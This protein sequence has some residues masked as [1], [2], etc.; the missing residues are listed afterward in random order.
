MEKLRVGVIGYGLRGHLAKHWHQPEEGGRSVITAF[1]ELD[2]ALI[3][4]FKAEITADCFITKDYHELLAREDVDAVAIL[5]EDWKHH[6][7]ALDAFK[8]GKHVFLEKPMAI[9]IEDC[10]DIINTWQATDLKLMIGFNMRYMPMFQTMKQYIDQGAIGEVKA[11]WCRHFVGR[12]GRYYYQDWH[13]NSKYTNSLLLQKG[14]HDIDVIH[15][16]GNSYTKKV[17]AFGSLDFYNDRKNFEADGLKDEWDIPIDVEDNNVLI[18]ELENGIKA[19]YLQ[20]HFTPDY[21]RNYVV[22]GTKGRM[23]NSMPD[24]TITI[25]S[26]N[27]AALHDQS[28][29]VIQMKPTVGVHSGGDVRIATSFVNYILDGKLPDVTPHD[30]RMSVAVGCQATDILRRGGGMAEIPE[31]AYDLNDLKR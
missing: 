14:S 9:S 31:A 26:R 10:D 25:K 4:K 8:A 2:E 3:D 20:C 5:T 11:I 12:G 19:S 13:R 15:M 17:S 29:V 16:L 28:D 7:H 1:S 23:E 30:G 27:T 21:H 24:N 22:I 6:Q 18:M